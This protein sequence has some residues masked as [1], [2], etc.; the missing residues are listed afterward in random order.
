MNFLFPCPDT[1]EMKERNKWEAVHF[2]TLKEMEKECMCNERLVFLW[3][4][5]RAK[6]IIYASL[7][8][9]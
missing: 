2:L 4:I 8:S 6:E 5:F 1:V 9:V 3:E 7:E